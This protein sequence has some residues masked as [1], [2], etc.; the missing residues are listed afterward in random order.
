MDKYNVNGT[1]M[2]MD[3]QNAEVVNNGTIMHLNGQNIT[4]RNHGTIMHGSGST[5]IVYRDR[6]V[7]DPQAEAAVK[8]LQAELE[9]AKKKLASAQR[10]NRTLRE[11]VKELEA[12]PKRDERL[13]HTEELLE[14]AMEVNREQAQRIKDLERGV[15][16]TY[17]KQQIDPWDLRPTNEQCA[18]LLRR[19]EA[20]IDFEE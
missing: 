8:K 19:L 5:R 14:C 3:L 9:Q 10:E 12:A 1:V 20:Y 18:R 16:D 13:R 2:R 7:T 4:L 15:C 11:R 6:F 17:L